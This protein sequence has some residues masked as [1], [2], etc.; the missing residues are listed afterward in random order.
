[1][2]RKEKKFIC[3]MSLLFQIILWINIIS[4]LSV[5][6]TYTYKCI[7]TSVS[8]SLS[9]SPSLSLKR[10]YKTTF[11]IFL[12][13]YKVHIRFCLQSS[14]TSSRFLA[15]SFIFQ[16]APLHFICF[17]YPSLLR[18]LFVSSLAG[19]LTLMPQQIE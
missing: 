14:H 4:P 8:L 11:F 13:M 10:F 1:M 9:L 18:F 12:M 15:L 2:H 3:N 7:L 16:C 5:L 6:P 19:Y 17:L